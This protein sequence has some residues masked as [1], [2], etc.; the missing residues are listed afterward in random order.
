MSLESKKWIEIKRLRKLECTDIDEA[1]L[2]WFKQKRS[3]NVPVS[4]P[5]LMTKAEKLAKLLDHEDFVC[6]T[7]TECLFY[8]CGVKFTD[9]RLPCISFSSLKCT[10]TFLNPPPPH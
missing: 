2:M 3:E 5:L 1:L 10:L 9:V 8:M 4:G 7:D 6:T